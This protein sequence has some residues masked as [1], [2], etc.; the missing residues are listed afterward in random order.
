[1]W[2]SGVN[3]DLNHILYSTQS[4]VEVSSFREL[5]LFIFKSVQEALFGMN[6]K[7]KETIGNKSS[8]SL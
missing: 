6:I 3:S 5:S 2:R 8:L 7:S 4:Y 1:M